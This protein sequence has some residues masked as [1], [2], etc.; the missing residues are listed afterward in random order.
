MYTY[1]YTQEGTWRAIWYV[2][3]VEKQ[4]RCVFRR[5]IDGDVSVAINHTGHRQPCRGGIEW[6]S[7]IGVSRKT[8]NGLGLPL[9]W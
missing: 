3:S 9:R 1:V 6:L 7:C 2:M 5:I 8:A 4:L